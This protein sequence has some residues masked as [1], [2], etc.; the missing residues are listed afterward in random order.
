[1]AF[2]PEAVEALR[3]R[4]EPIDLLQEVLDR[5]RHD[6]GPAPEEEVEGTRVREGFASPRSGPKARLRMEMTPFF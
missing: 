6:H 5:L 4:D 3:V 2:V 1:V